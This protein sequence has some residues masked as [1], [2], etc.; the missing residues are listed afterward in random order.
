[1]GWRV[2]LFRGSSIAGS[3]NS[4]ESESF[5]IRVLWHAHTCHGLD[6]RGRMAATARCGLSGGQ[7]SFVYWGALE[8]P[9]HEMTTVHYSNVFFHVCFGHS[10][11]SDVC[12][13]SRSFAESD[14]F[15]KATHIGV[16]F[17]GRFGMIL[18]LLAGCGLYHPSGMCLGHP[19]MGGACFQH[20]RHNSCTSTWYWTVIM[21]GAFGCQGELPPQPFGRRSSG[22]M[23]NSNGGWRNNSTIGCFSSRLNWP[24]QVYR[25][26]DV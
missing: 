14:S 26:L 16:F 4:A 3:Q 25:E 21:Q 17:Q 1:M 7:I 2:D 12:L 10:S 15:G 8:R 22:R 5:R 19:K 23:S 9:K 6:S 11:A 13:G 18:D 24:Y 20:L